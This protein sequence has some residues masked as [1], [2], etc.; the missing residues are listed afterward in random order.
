MIPS[1][2]SCLAEVVAD[3]GLAF[4]VVD[5]VERGARGVVAD[6]GVD[7]L[8]IEHDM[9]AGGVAVFAQD[10]TTGRVYQA[11]RLSWAPGPGATPGPE[12]AEAEAAGR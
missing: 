8:G 3:D 4:G 7:D 2:F 5:D 9:V 1:L 12:Q 10:E 6:D 11:N